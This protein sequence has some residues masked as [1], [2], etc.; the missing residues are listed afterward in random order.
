MADACSNR[1]LPIS[2]Y[3]MTVIKQLPSPSAP[4][5]LDRPEDNDR[6]LEFVVML[7]IIIRY[8]SPSARGTD[9]DIV[10]TINAPHYKGQPPGTDAANGDVVTHSPIV[11]R[12]IEIRER[13]RQTLRLTDEAAL[14]G[15]EPDEML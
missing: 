4:N 8:T 12:A 7:L 9:T 11:R 14:A 6:H 5:S 10:C 2:A 1:D 15:V 3:L 13:F